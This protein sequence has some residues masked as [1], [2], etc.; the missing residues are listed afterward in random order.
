MN[1]MDLF[2]Q[3]LEEREKKIEAA[4]KIIDNEALKEIR[5]IF[6]GKKIRVV[7]HD[8]GDTPTKKEGAVNEVL[9]SAP[10]KDSSLE[11]KFNFD[12]GRNSYVTP[13]TEI[14][15]LE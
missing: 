6:V 2:K 5:E 1:L 12:Q 11:F 9:N 4:I 13:E 3:V 7:R 15:M 8:C 10:W 14:T